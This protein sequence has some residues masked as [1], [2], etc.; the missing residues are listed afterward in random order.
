MTDKKYINIKYIKDVME[1]KSL[2]A[3]LMKC[4]C[5]IKERDICNNMGNITHTHA[6]RLCHMG[7]RL[8]EKKPEYKNIIQDFLSMRAS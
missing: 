7:I 6:S 8:I 4:L 3:F 2:C 1:F 5:D